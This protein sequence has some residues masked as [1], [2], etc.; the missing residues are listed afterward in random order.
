VDGGRWSES[1]VSVATKWN[2][3]TNIGQVYS[4]MV[5]VACLNAQDR[6]SPTDAIYDFEG[7]AWIP[8]NSSIDSTGNFSIGTSDKTN[9]TKGAV[10]GECVYQYG[11]VAIKSI[12]FFLATFLNGTVK[13]GSYSY[14]YK[15]A[16]QLQAIYNNGGLTFDRLDETWRNL[17]DSITKYM[18]EH[19]DANF[20][21]PATV[22]AFRDQTCVHNRWPFL[23]YPAALVLLAVVFFVCMMFETRRGATSR[24]DW[25]SS[26]LALLFPWIRPES[27][28]KRGIGR[29]GQ[30]ERDGTDCR[31]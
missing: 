24:D 1:L 4:G 12:G 14:D 5:N 19:G 8:Y 21:A 13:P 31:A 30:S 20:S 17:S 10:S 2:M 3:A 16:A 27:I 15:G 23:A 11:G 9:I 22:E 28:E 29:I 6:Q 7:K 25:K 18:Q 26:P